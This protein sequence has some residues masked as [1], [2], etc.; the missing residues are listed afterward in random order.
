MV[1]EAQLWQQSRRGDGQAFGAIFDLHQRR[2]HLTALRVTDNANE[3]EDLVAATFLELWRRRDTVPIAEGSV[4]PWMLV[5]LNN[6][7]RNTTRAARRH[8]RFLSTLPTPTSADITLDR[9]EKLHAERDAGILAS[10]T[11]HHRVDS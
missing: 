8:R 5:T 4:L 9:L 3:A 11:V 10:V 2:F 1:S 7:C 6:L